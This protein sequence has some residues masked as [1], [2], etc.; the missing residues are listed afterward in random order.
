MNVNLV[1]AD[2]VFQI[3]QKW[4]SRT[5]LSLFCFIYAVRILRLTM[6]K[7]NIPIALFFLMIFGLL[8]SRAILSITEGIW[9][10]FAIIRYKS[11]KN[12][13]TKDPLL[14]WSLCP[15]LLFF[16][17]AWQEPLQ[18]SNY[19]YLLTLMAYPVAA[20]SVVGFTAGQ[21]RK[22]VY[23][24]WFAA[25]LAG[26]LYS[27]FYFFQDSHSI[28]E[29]IGKGQSLP[30]LMDEDH[31]R[32]GI[33]LCAGLTLLLYTKQST[34]ALKWILCI[35]LAI[36]ILFLSVRTAW[37]MALVI[38]AVYTFGKYHTAIRK[39]PT[40]AIL[41]LGLFILSV[42]LAYTS[43]PSIQ[44][45][46]AYTIYDW[47]QIRQGS[48][49]P[50]YSDATRWAVNH[51][52]WQAIEQGNGVNVGWNGITETITVHFG[53]IYPGNKTNFH[54]PFNQ[55]LFWWIGAGLGGMLLFSAWL[56]YPLLWG[57]QK[58]N[59]ALAGWSLAIAI[60]CMVESNLAF[61]FGV[62]LH[63]WPIAL[64]WYSDKT[65]DTTSVSGSF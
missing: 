28:L 27:L 53:N 8:C 12:R 30:T 2:Q 52:A 25:T 61:Q 29:G 14:L 59:Y 10:L 56:L 13:L 37:I 1:D 5:G 26:I 48:F 63:A 15:V 47:Q 55:Y 38:I 41:I 3:L 22:I 65:Q 9:M 57:I 21:S 58:R 36:F 24:I 43:F 64:L 17:G 11:W 46:I 16:L 39:N 49:Y 23:R 31:I 44:Q 34:P 19:D 20:F 50:E 42:W 18:S 33:F 35:V 62:W 60:S 4:F 40:R 6:D 54:W 45:K 51:A 32:F 7:K